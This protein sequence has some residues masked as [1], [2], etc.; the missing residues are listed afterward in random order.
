MA[1]SRSASGSTLA[2]TIEIDLVAQNALGSLDF[3]RRRSLSCL[4]D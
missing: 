1:A 3:N 2:A 4:S